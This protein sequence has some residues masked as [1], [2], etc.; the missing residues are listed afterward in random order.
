MLDGPFHA[1]KAAWPALTKSA[2]G[3][4]VVTAS[5]ASY[6]GG[7]Q[8]AAYCAAKHGVL[9]LVRTA[10]L[11][12]GA[13]GLTVNAVAPGWMDTGLMR[14]QLEAQ[15]ASRGVSTEEVIAL[16]RASQPGNRFVDVL[17]VAATIGFLVS[18]CA[19]G[20]NGE[21]ITIDLGARSYRQILVTAVPVRRQRLWADGRS[22]WR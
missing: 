3:R 14:G 7:R 4:I 2:G 11:E 5:V 12:G 21:C 6:G 1:M 9:G 15:A 10:A 16:F 8:K 13:H 17:E 18:P 22:T 19:S 20:I